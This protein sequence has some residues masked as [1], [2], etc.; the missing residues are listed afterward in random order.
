MCGNAWLSPFQG[1]LTQPHTYQFFRL[2]HIKIGKATH[3][4]SITEISLLKIGFIDNNSSG[5]CLGDTWAIFLLLLAR[6][7][8]CCC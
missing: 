2:C 3:T 7:R 6:R 8:T 5:G 4:C 1:Q